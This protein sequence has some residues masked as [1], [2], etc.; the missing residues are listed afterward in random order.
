MNALLKNIAEK[1]SQ[2]L[3]NLI[4]EGNDDILAAIHKTE[5]QAQLQGMNPKITL[6]FKIT[7]DLD[8]NTFDCDLSWAIK[9]SLGVSHSLDNPNPQNLPMASTTK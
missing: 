6:G 9:Q 4:E 2:D 7:V 8:K 3:S 1:S 5:A